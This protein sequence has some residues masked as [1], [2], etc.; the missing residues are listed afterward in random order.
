MLLLQMMQFLS[1]DARHCP[2]T[3]S[4]LTCLCCVCSLFLS[5]VCIGC[6]REGSG[7]KS[8]CL[9]RTYWFSVVEYS[10]VSS[11]SSSKVVPSWEAVS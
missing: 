11:A 7:A 5:L 9:A 4:Q 1:P 6:G 8:S 2:S 3:A 10:G